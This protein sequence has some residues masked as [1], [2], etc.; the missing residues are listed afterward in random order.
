MPPIPLP[1]ASTWLCSSLWALDLRV[2]LIDIRTAIT[3]QANAATHRPHVPADQCLLLWTVPPDA[4]SGW[5]S[6]TKDPLLADSSATFHA[7]Q[8]DLIF[9]HSYRI[10]G[11]LALLA[12]GHPRLGR[13]HRGHMYPVVVRLPPYSSFI[14]NMKFPASPLLSSPS[15][16]FASLALVW[17][18]RARL[19]ALARACGPVSFAPLGCFWSPLPDLS[20]P[21]CAGSAVA[22]IRL[23]DPD[24]AAP[25]RCP[26]KSSRPERPSLPHTHTRPSPSSLPLLSPSQER[27]N[28]G[29]PALRD[30]RL[31][32][33][34]IRQARG[35]AYHGRL[36][37][38]TIGLLTATLETFIQD[39]YEF[40]VNTMASV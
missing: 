14:F 29:P 11:S 35:C 38:R 10:G 15:S 34:R 17:G 26:A 25:S 36:F 16:F 33:N 32:T 28:E 7:T 30:H 39:R 6:L 13:A 12:A 27:S 3:R 21:W 9:G 40:I 37:H 22:A 23:P 20:W 24:F 5:C 31:V 4:S 2:S 1:F 8:L 18:P 19:V